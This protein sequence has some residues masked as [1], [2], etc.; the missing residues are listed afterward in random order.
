MIKLKVYRIYNTIEDK[1]IFDTNSSSE[2]I[3][4]V[5]LIAKENEHDPKIINSVD[6]CDRYILTECTQNLS[7]D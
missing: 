2:Y 4:K 3:D 7:L 6:D 5:K 1:W